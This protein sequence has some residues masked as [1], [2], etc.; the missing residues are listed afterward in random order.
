MDEYIKRFSTDKNGFIQLSLSQM[1]E[2][3]ELFG[4]PPE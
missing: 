4:H 1:Q 2:I 3:D